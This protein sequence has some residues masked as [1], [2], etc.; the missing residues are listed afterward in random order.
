MIDVHPD[1][2]LHRDDL[3]ADER[4]RLEAH[5][6]VCH[7]CAIEIR[8]ARDFRDEKLSAADD[9][10]DDVI[11]RSVRGA[12][13]AA[14]PVAKRR[15]VLPYLLVAAAAMFT[16]FAWAKLRPQD[17]APAPPAPVVTAAPPPPA[18]TMT[19]A[20]TAV[21]E[22][23]QPEPAPSIVEAPKPVPQPSV[24]AKAIATAAELFASANE[25]RRGGEVDK[26]IALYRDLQ[27][28]HPASPEA[29]TSRVAFGRLLL[30]KTG[31]A[32]GAKA[33]FSAYLAS[34]EAGTLAE[35][36][37]VGLALAAA[38]LGDAAGEKAAWQELLAKHPESVHAERARKRIAELEK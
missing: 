25:A 29:L 23:K 16:F 3:T 1:E 19:V 18:P 6:K 12:M 37:R 35:E 21:E 7:A 5:L 27:S 8:V 13:L 2:L 14:Q 11:A 20:P 22:P 10:D 17:P 28:H 24:S 38:K 15:K 33:Q 4:A 36:A 32:P 30:D 9:D 26:A 34:A 31:D